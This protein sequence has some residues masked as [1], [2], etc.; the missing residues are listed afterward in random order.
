[1]RQAALY[2]LNWRCRWGFDDD[3]GSWSKENVRADLFEPYHLN[4]PDVAPHGGD[5]TE[6]DARR[7]WFIVDEKNNAIAA[8]STEGTIHLPTNDAIKTSQS[9]HALFSPLISSLVVRHA[10]PPSAGKVTLGLP[11]KLSA[12]T[13]KERLFLFGFAAGGL[14]TS[15]L[16][17][18]SL[19][20]SA[21]FRAA[22][23]DV[24]CRSIPAHAWASVDYHLDWLH[25]ALQWH[26]GASVP[27][28]PQDLLRT[29]TRD[30]ASLVAGSQ[31][32]T[33]LV[34]AWADEEKAHVVLVEAKAYGAWDNKQAASKVARIAAIRAAGGEHVD[35]RL[36]L[37]SPRKPE[38][39]ATL[40]W[41][42]WARD[43]KGKVSWLR[44]PVPNLRVTTERCD[45]D[46]RAST[47]GTYWHIA[48]PR[49]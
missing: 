9:E 7:Y 27:L 30:G 22:L 10:Q 4:L 24:T 11:A 36:A 21:T 34:V 37:C 17:S 32:D 15:E 46:G 29:T 16:H 26:S 33:D 44:L 28:Q 25:A 14:E 45:V 3:S 47:Q 1:L 20:L 6:A 49:T 39:L 43:H 8:F 13:R 31:E 19:Q 12:F 23:G 18:P 38:K 42:Q 2:G 40:D 5:I 35:L 41:P 48:G